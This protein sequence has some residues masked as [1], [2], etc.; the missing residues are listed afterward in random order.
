LPNELCGYPKYDLDAKQEQLLAARIKG[1]QLPRALAYVDRGTVRG[2]GL[3]PLP[4][5][6]REV[7]Q[8]DSLLRSNGWQTGLHVQEMALEEEVKRVENP[9][10]L[11]I[12][13]HGFLQPD[14]ER[15]V[16][17]LLQM[18]RTW[19]VLNPLFR[20]GVC[21]A[22]AQRTLSKKEG[23]EINTG[24]DDGILTAYEA[25]NMNLDQTELVVLSACETGLGDIKYGE[26]VYGLQ[27]AFQVA[28]A[29]YV[30]MSL[31]KVADTAT[32]EL[33]TTFYREWSRAGDV[34]TGFK[35]AQRQIREKYHNPFYW[36]AFV[37]VGV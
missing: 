24:I 32:Q 2:E 1:E 25:M 26:G 27:R 6:A 29:R 35:E 31:W 28:G 15:P 4:G 9:R 33:M 14:V 19:P 17:Q 23:E 20:I 13:S 3:N 36:G 12:A 30:M 11:H 10:V 37:L 5:T 8:I 21:L 22:G 16:E 18:K 34:R 7:T